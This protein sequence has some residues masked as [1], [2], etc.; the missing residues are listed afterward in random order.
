MVVVVAGR[1]ERG[2]EPD[3]AAVGGHAEPERV[4]VE[5][6]RAVE[7]RDPEVHMA[8]ADGGVDG[9]GLHGWQC[10]AAPRR[11]A[12]VDPPNRRESASQWTSP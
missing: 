1:E 4:A 5:G 11:P 10:P 7:V 9:F 8:D 12:S 6:D 3:R 2:V